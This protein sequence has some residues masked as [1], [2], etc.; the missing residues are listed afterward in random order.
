MHSPL[1]RKVSPSPL[2]STCQASAPTRVSGRFEQS[3]PFEICRH[4]STPATIAD[5]ID[6]R[7]CRSGQRPRRV[8]SIERVELLSR[9]SV[10]PI[11]LPSPCRMSGAV[12]SHHGDRATRT[13]RR[14]IWL[15]QIAECIPESTLGSSVNFGD[16]EEVVIVDRALHSCFDEMSRVYFGTN[17]YH[18]G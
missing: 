3:R 12:E 5:T 13:S 6:A 15:R 4:R 7:R 17:K 14:T 9:R 10:S 1:L 11:F 18:M 8:G 16:S 2:P